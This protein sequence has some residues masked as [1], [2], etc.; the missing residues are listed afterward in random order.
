M[1]IEDRRNDDKK[2]CA[3]T[4][5]ILVTDSKWY[6]LLEGVYNQVDEE[7]PIVV[8]DLVNNCIVTTCRSTF[9]IEEDLDNETIKEIIPRDKLRLVIE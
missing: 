4:G 9:C 8:C 3:G 7:Y 6:L 5:D 1:K 2:K